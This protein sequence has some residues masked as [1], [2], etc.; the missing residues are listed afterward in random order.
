MTDYQQL[1]MDE[2]AR[3]LEFSKGDVLAFTD[4][5][6]KNKKFITAVKRAIRTGELTDA[7]VYNQALEVANQF[8][9]EHGKEFDILPDESV[10]LPGGLELTGTLNEL[11]LLLHR[12]VIDFAKISKK[13][14]R[15]YD[16]AI[17]G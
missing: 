1:L 16:P 5:L 3:T 14:D 13:K 12:K 17:L 9:A 6:A 2:L 4:E 8:V 11:G 10:I 15:V 7:D